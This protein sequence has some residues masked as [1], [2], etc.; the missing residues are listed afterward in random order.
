MITLMEPIVVS[1]VN[2]ASAACSSIRL[3]LCL[4]RMSQSD[5]VKVLL[6]RLTSVLA[7]PPALWAPTHSIDFFLDQGM[8]IMGL[9]SFQSSQWPVPSLK[10]S[11]FIY[12]VSSSC[13]LTLPAVKSLFQWSSVS[14]RRQLS[15][16]VVNCLSSC[17]EK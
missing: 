3:V 10:S 2:L 5:G 7:Q 1:V 15:L 17:I 13:Q 16:P 4:G 6:L 12:A 14:S 11:S 8:M 9:L